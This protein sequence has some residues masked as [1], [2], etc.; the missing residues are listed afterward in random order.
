M[1]K[2]NRFSTLLLI[3][4]AVTVFISCEKG[5]DSSTTPPPTN[6]DVIPAAILDASISGDYS[7]QIHIDLPGNYLD[8]GQ[9]EHL[10]GGYTSVNDMMIITAM[11]N[12]GNGGIV[13]IAHTGGI[14]TG[15]FNYID[16]QTSYNNASIGAQGFIAPSGSLIITEKKYITTIGNDKDYYISGSFSG[17]MANQDNPPKTVYMSG[18]FS[19]IHVPD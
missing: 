11:F 7:E 1:Q 9:S 16:S 18:T 10:N 12:S 3:I 8:T 17:S 13:L 14:N 6:T 2:I 19:G 5:S 4:L 15:T